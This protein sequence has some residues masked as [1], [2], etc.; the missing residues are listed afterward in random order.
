MAKSNKKKNDPI[1]SG[2]EVKESNDPH[3]D[4]DVPGFPDPPSGKEDLK[5]KEPIKKAYKK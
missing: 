4:Q 5:K 3:I 1:N 2:K